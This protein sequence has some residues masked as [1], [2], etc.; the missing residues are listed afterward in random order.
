[1]SGE[2]EGT[3]EVRNVF[4]SEKEINTT[5]L[6]GEV[7]T[8]PVKSP[9]E[10]VKLNTHVPTPYIILYSYLSPPFFPKV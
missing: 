10:E 3:E 5:A 4:F 6:S 7:I 8:E 1:M 9:E 2:G